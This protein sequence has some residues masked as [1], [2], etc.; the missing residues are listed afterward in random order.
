M[1]PGTSGSSSAKEANTRRCEDQLTSVE[2]QMCN[3]YSM[4][5]I[6]FTVSN[7]LSTHQALFLHTKLFGDFPELSGE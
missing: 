4:N 5:D 6:V 1:L 2:C 7:N 3:K